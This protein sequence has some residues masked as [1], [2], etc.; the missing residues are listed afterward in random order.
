MRELFL[1]QDLQFDKIVRSLV[2]RTRTT[3]VLMHGACPS[4]TPRCVLYES[5][6]DQIHCKNARQMTISL[7]VS[8]LLAGYRNNANYSKQMKNENS[9][10]RTNFEL[11]LSNFLAITYKQ[12]IC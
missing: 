11:I 5:P 6:F 4:R 8:I 12:F 3:A 1:L 2:L 7:Y 9:L 10:H